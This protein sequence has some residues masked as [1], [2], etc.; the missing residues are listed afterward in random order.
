M[1]LLNIGKKEKNNMIE[2]SDLNFDGIISQNNNLVI[3]CWA[4]WCKPCKIYAPTF[5]EV[6][7]EAKNVEFAKLETESCPNLST[8]LGI[9]SIP[10]TIFIKNKTV[11]DV[12]I[13]V[14]TKE[15][16]LNK[17]NSIYNI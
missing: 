2:L 5:E 7:K 6:S 3:D 11:I 8:Y 9:K 14:I 17:I 1:I 4:D 13:G 16:L 12:V 15:D 10:T